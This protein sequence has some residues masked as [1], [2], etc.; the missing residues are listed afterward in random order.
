MWHLPIV[1]ISGGIGNFVIV[2]VAIDRLVYIKSFMPRGAPPFC[3][4]IVARKLI[5][6]IIVFASLTNIPCFLIFEVDEYGYV[7]TTDFYFS[8]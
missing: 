7:Q 4:P 8:E 2:G 1:G 3:C 6:G 5:L